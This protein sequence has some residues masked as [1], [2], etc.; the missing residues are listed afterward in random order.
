MIAICTFAGVR[1]DAEARIARVEWGRLE[2]TRPRPAGSNARL[3]E[4][5]F[6][7]GVPVARL[8]TTD[9]AI[10]WG[11]ASLNQAR[12][13]ALCGKSL[14]ELLTADPQTSPL[15]RALEF[16]LLDLIGQLTGLP[17]Y[18]LFAEEAPSTP[19]RVRC[20]DTSLY[21]DDLHL[22]DD[23]AAVDLLVREAQE[24]WEKGHRAF[25]IKVGRG[26]RHMPLEAGTQRDIAIIRAIRA[27]VG[28]EAPLMID[29]NNGWNL[30]LT[31]RVL[32]ETADCHIHW[33]E[34]AFH[35]DPVLYR[36]LKEW[37][38]TRGIDTLIADGEGDAAP[39]LVNWAREGLIDVL[40]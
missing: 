15:S 29:A 3:G 38:H 23:A 25:K 1:F 4:H 39:A 9:G 31:K 19:L 30:N 34:E 12:A 2:G 17:V 11:R 37:L 26:A 8:T 24:G 18:A 21:F 14:S 36:D 22:S 32:E 33:M 27:A 20:Y 28:P 10:G 35:E 5:G 16:P 7:V 40:Q 13:E 6:Q